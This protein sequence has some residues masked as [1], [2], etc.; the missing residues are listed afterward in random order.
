MPLSSRVEFQ[1]LKQLRGAGSPTEYGRQGLRKR[2][3]QSWGSGLGGSVKVDMSP[4]LSRGWLS[5]LNMF[6]S[7]VTMTGVAA[8]AVM[9]EGVVVMGEEEEDMVVVEEAVEVGRRDLFPMSPLSLPLSAICPTTL[10]KVML[11]PF[12]RTC[13]SAL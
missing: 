11:T 1:K 9:A 12:S 4:R 13:A 7:G 10:S 5:L 6:L 2:V 3:S 8:V